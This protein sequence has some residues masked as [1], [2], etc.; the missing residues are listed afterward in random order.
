MTRKIWT[1]HNGNVIPAPYVPAIDKE[2]D[3]VAQKVLKQALNLNGKL[4]AFK[5]ESIALCDA[6]F[7]KMMADFK[8][9]KSGKGNYSITSFNKEI[10]IEISVQ[11]RVEFDDLILVAQEKIEEYLTE[12][13]GGIDKELRYFIDRAF[14]T[15]K[16]KLDVKRVLELFKWN[17]KHKK[18][19]EAM[20]ILKK[21]ISHNVSKRYMRVWKKNEMGEYKA[22]ELNFSAL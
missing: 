22:V 1:D 20:E 6:V 11:E 5:Q 18:W 19:L 15:T 9:K 14:K 10:K 13:T 21:S 7:D 2:R 16:G 12:K 17:I 4:T 3:R 8:V